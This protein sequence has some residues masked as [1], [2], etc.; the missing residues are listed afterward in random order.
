MIMAQIKKKIVKGKDLTIIEVTGKV[1]SGEIIDA[2]VD[3]YESAFTL[4]LLWDLSGSDMSAITGDHLH[5]ILSIAKSYGHLR[6]GGKTALFTTLPLGYGIA[7]MYEILS[8]VNQHP[9]QNSVFR[10][11]DDAMAWLES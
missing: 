10:S 1:T 9:I 3:F 8:D 2:I 11:L 6:E 7:R 5:E 4:N